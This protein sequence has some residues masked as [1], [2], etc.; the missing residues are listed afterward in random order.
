MKL[1][2][3][4]N[5]YERLVPKDLAE[6]WDNV[7][8]IIGDENM[9]V[10]RVLTT[11]EATNEVIDYAIQNDYDLIFCH[12]PIIFSPIKNI[13]NSTLSKKIIKLIKND[14]AVYVSHTNVDNYELG[15]NHL[16][17]TMLGGKDI[18][19]AESG[20][21]FANVFYEDGK[22]LA[23]DIKEKFHLN[24]VNFIGDISSKVEKV[25]LV[26]G[27]GSSFITDDIIDSVD[28]FLTGDIK[29]HTAVDVIEKG[30][31]LIDVTHYGSE[32]IAGELFRTM[33]IN[34]NLD[35]CV[36]SYNIFNNPF[37]TI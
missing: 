19:R 31:R 9:E 36:D 18:F 13:T 14:I 11:I 24:Y 1:K 22:S 28:V 8:L 26:T 6:D 3:I 23:D 4:I 5:S 29:Y 2:K 7:G 16:F 21:F 35:L 25:A 17:L 33:L 27:S 12:H 20:V 10:G 30:G 37:N 32:F 34:M 15:L